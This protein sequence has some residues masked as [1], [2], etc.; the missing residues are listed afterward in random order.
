M[1]VIGH[2]KRYLLVFHFRLREH[3]ADKFDAMKKGSKSVR[4]V[5]RAMGKLLKV[6]IASI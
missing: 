5:P 3:L 2:I 1:S 6:L 4:E